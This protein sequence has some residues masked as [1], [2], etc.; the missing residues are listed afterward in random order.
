MLPLW[1]LDITKQSVR[2]DEFQSLVRQIDHV[3]LEPTDDDEDD[4]DLRD[5]DLSGLD[6]ED[7]RE[8]GLIDD[9][10]QEGG[11]EAFGETSS[12]FKGTYGDEFDEESDEDDSRG[13]V[14]DIK[15]IEEQV[16]EEDKKK[17][18]K[19][20]I[21][22]GNYWYYSSLSYEDYFSGLDIDDPNQIVDIGNRL[23]DFQEAVVGKAKDFIKVS[24]TPLRV[25][26]GIHPNE[27][28]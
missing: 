14:N 13:S 19:Q 2:R 21:I 18:A 26:Y 24:S 20:A 25:Y 10:V 5:L 12:A 1:I 7:L 15:T 17:A 22:E 16:E 23:Y 28:R 3:F 6:E 9:T 8:L 4:I 11:K 27:K